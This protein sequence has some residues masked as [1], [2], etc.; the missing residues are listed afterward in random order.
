MLYQCPLKRDNMAG[1]DPK[2]CK[3]IKSFYFFELG[4]HAT[5]RNATTIFKVPPLS[6]QICHS[7]VG[8][9]G[10]GIFFVGWNPF[11][12]VS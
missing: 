2:V 7:V 5:F 11:I 10:P 8:R 3:K 1:F 6:K 9:G 12:F 4:A